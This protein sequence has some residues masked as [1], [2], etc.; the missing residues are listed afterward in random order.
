MLMHYYKQLVEENA[1]LKN[2]NNTLNTYMTAYDKQKANSAT[3][4]MLLALRNIIVGLRVNFLTGNVT[5]L[6]LA[7]LAI[8]VVIVVVGIYFSSFK[9]KN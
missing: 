9:D 7:A 4:A 5:G 3:G 2:D 8:G 6:G 1:T